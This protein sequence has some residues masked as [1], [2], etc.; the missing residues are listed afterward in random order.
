MAAERR[1]DEAWS[2]WLSNVYQLPRH[3][4]NSLPPLAENR[5]TTTT[6]K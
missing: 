1:S 6:L 2:G 5:L 4:Q 3:G